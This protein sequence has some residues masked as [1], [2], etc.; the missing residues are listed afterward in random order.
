MKKQIVFWNMSAR[1][2]HYQVRYKHSD[3]KGSTPPGCC[4]FGVDGPNREPAPA[5]ACGHVALRQTWE[6]TRSGGAAQ[7]IGRFGRQIAGATGLWSYETL[8]RRLSAGKK[9]PR[10]AA[11]RRYNARLPTILSCELTFEELVMLDEAI[12]G[13]IREM[14][15]PFLV[16]VDRDM[17]K[18]Y[19][20]CGT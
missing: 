16:S 6:P 17:R 11:Q 2:N 15:G 13:R 8:Q 3:Q 19:R 18:N 7:R 12:A 5:T 1:F 10:A 20:F 14:C 4:L 9:R